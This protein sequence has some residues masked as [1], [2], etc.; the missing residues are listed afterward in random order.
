MFKKYFDFQY[1]KQAKLFRI[2][3]G[4]PQKKALPGL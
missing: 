3:S 1:Y 4:C 2:N